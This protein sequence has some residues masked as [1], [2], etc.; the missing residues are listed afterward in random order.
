MIEKAGKSKSSIKKA[1]YVIS[2][3]YLWAELRSVDLKQ[4]LYY[5]DFLNSDQASDIVDFIQFTSSTQNEILKVKT[6]QANTG[7]SGRSNIISFRNSAKVSYNYTSNEVYANRL[8]ILRKFLKWVISERQAQRIDTPNLVI[9]RS[10]LAINRIEGSIPRIS[11]RQE[12]EQLEAV[13]LDV[14]ERIA[15]VLHP[16]HAQNPFSTP[17]IRQRNYLLLLLM[18]ESGGRRGEIYQTKS[19]DIIS[20]TL[21]YDI[22]TSKTTPRTLPVSR[23]LVDAFEAYHHLYWQQLNGKGKRS[24]YLFVKSSGERLT[25]RAVNH[26]IETVRNKIPEVPPWFHTHTIRRTFNHQLSLLIDQKRAEGHEISHEE[27]RKIRNRLNGW[28]RTSRMGEIYNAR[29]LREKAD[30][31]AEL[32]LN[33]IGGSNA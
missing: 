17:F 11:S 4:I 13:D 5:G 10:I 7:R 9:R 21:Q 32:A 28:A 24:G 15:K 1:L 8:R 31:L 30:R 27:E 18:I 25:L 33:T 14:I 20:A 19:K 29:H 2:R 23:L 16:K 12:N 22:K 6:K 3:L 26:I